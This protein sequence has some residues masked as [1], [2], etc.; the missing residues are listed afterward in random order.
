S[1]TPTLSPYTTLFRSL[2]RRSNVPILPRWPHGQNSAAGSEE[3]L[4]HRHRGAVHGASM[5]LITRAFLL[6]RATTGN[7]ASTWY[8]TPS[9]T[10]P[11]SASAPASPITPYSSLP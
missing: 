1:P 11:L 4:A 6:V 9:P 5:R 2:L 10:M 3:A 7:V 8:P